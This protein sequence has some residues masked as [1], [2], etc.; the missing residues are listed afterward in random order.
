LDDKEDDPRKVFP[1]TLWRVRVVVVASWCG[2]ST[3]GHSSEPAK[4][5]KKSRRFDYVSKLGMTGIL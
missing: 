4:L 3:S 5:P 2:F 1:A